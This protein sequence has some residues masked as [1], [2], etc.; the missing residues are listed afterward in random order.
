MSLNLTKTVVHFLKEHADTK[1][2]AREIAEWIFSAYPEECR[3]KMEQSTAIDTEAELLQQLVAEIGS[4]RP[5]MQKRFHQVK[6][7]EGRPRKY[8]WSEKTDLGE[9]EEAESDT[10]ASGVSTVKLTEHDTYPMLADYLWSELHLYSLRIN[11]KRSS[12]SRGS[13]GNKW[14][15]PDMV[16]IE[17]MTRHWSEEVKKCVHEYRDQ[18]SKLWSFE[19]KL[20][21]NRSNVREVYFQTVSNSS[22][23]NYGY[24]VAAEIEGSETLSE[25]RMLFALHGIGVIKL[26]TENPT[27]SQ[28]IIPAKEKSEIE[29]STVSRIADQNRDFERFVK[30]IR[31]FHQTGELKTGDWDIPEQESR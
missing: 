10:V 22:W 7:T 1:H 14:L 30:Q 11:E 9:V 26:D 6:T 17:D 18:R 2:K 28:I 20:L 19:V 31:Q 12:N 5:R 25:M 24:L 16:A 23:A 21:I 8:Y 29:W 15:H 4:Q 3:Q 27:E 13:G